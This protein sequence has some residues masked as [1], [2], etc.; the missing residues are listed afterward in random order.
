[1]ATR[2]FD[3]F[4]KLLVELRQKAGIASQTEFATLVKS[5]QQTVSRWEAGQSRPA[6][7]RCR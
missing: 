4:G 3:I 2:P 5:T 6:T 1:M 7:S